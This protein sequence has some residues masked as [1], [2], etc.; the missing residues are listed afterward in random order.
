MGRVGAPSRPTRFADSDSAACRLAVIGH[1]AAA[2]DVAQSGAL[3]ELT[4][5]RALELSA[6]RDSLW[7]DRD[8]QFDWIPGTHRMLYTTISAAAGRSWVCSIDVETRRTW[9]VIEGQQ[10][11][12]SPDGTKLAFL[13]PGRDSAGGRTALQLWLADIEGGHPKQLTALHPDSV[14]TVLSSLRYRWSPDSRRIV[15]RRSVIG[16]AAAEIPSDSVRRRHGSSAVVYP[17][18]A[19]AEDHVRRSKIRLLDVQTQEEE[20]VVEANALLGSIGWLG[21]DSIYYETEGAPKNELELF[22]H[23]MVYSLQRR[24]AGTLISGYNRQPKY[25]PV[26][27]PTGTQV[28]FQADPGQAIA[29]PFR[30]EL[31]VYSVGKATT[32]VLTRYAAITPGAWT[33]D[34]RAVVVTDGPSTHRKLYSIS[35]NGARRALTSGPGVNAAPKFSSDGRLLA[36]I[37]TD[38]AGTQT[39]RIGDWD[40]SALSGVRD[41]GVLGKPTEGLMVGRTSAIQWRSK[42]GLLV[43]GYLTLPVGYD[44]SR[45]YPVVVLLHGGPS[46]G[47]TPVDLGEWPG[48]AYSPYLLASAGYAVLRPDYR[49]SG[50]LGFDKLLAARRRGDVLQRDLDDIVAGTRYLEARGIADSTRLFLLGHSAGSDE[51]NWIIT[52][53]NPFRA[54]VSFEGGDFFWDWG[55]TAWHDANYTWE[56][57]LGGGSPME[58]PGTFSRNSAI[59]SARG[60]RTPT[61]FVNCAGRNAGN[62]GSMLWLYV[63]LKRQHVDAEYVLYP[64]DQ[65]VLVKPA[66]RADMLDRIL[67]WIKT[68]DAGEAA[69]ST[70]RG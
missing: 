70:R 25:F 38:P 37:F 43:D 36:W 7:R 17:Y 55:G 30:R 21:P 41:I 26:V 27:S 5:E 65:H 10:P 23:I 14:E 32:T 40:S 15:Y 49:R 56:W 68:H 60:A 69:V 8:L 9:P 59:L 47:V 48:S 20:V 13:A 3:L 58:R 62:S 6:K 39:L 31:A 52:Q 67:L 22:S 63:A 66:N 51:A 4:P 29:Y 35:L 1:G 16:N 54:A 33:P 28:A 2:S 45:K 18:A 44:R 57:Y 42:D 61:M 64:D 24:T 11:S 12:P 19:A 53:H 50:M 46:G 34:E